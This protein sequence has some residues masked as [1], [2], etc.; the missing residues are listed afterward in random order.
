MSLLLFD[1]GGTRSRFACSPDGIEM[2]EPEICDTPQDFDEAIDLFSNLCKKVCGDNVHK[3]VGGI[4]GALN[5][6]KTGLY[7]APN[8]MHWEG[9]D[10]TKEFGEKIKA[11][12]YI[13]NDTAVVGLGEFAYGAG[14]KYD[15]VVYITISTGVNGVKISNGKIDE[16]TYGFEIGHQIIDFDDSVIETTASRGTLEDFVSGREFSKRH[17]GAHPKTIRNEKIWRQMAEWTAVGL[18]N[19]ILHW[20]PQMV[21]MGGSMMRDIPINIVEQKTHDLLSDVHPDLPIIVKAKLDDVGGLWGALEF[22]KQ[23]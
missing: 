4:A 13:E 14:E 18:Y 11:P 3:A 8:L 1:I 21:I 23:V 22:A 7:R 10:F 20:S 15:I 16:S 17:G 9:R 5:K 12:V 2:G 6:E 19:T